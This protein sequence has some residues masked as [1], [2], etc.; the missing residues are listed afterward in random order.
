[1]TDIKDQLKEI[2]ERLEAAK[3]I[4]ENAGENIE[5]VKANYTMGDEY[6]DDVSRL[7]KVV[8]V[9][10]DAIEDIKQARFKLLDGEFL[11]GDFHNVVID[12]FE[13]QQKAREIMGGEG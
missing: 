1:M 13:A 11:D 7:L 9:L 12:K 6:L 5:I 10:W 2:R 8:E 3:E 4:Y